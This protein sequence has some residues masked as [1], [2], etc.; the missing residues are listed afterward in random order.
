MRKPKF[1]NRML[2]EPK[3]F[4]SPYDMVVGYI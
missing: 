2:N 1:D 3:Q 4:E